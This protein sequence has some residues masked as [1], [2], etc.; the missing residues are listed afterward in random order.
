MFFLTYY[1]YYSFVRKIT[2]NE[3]LLTSQT[4]PSE[5]HPCY[6]MIHQWQLSNSLP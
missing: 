1:G 2:K 6:H 5:Q 4:R 3:S